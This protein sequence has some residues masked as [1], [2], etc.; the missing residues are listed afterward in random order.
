MAPARPKRTKKKLR[1]EAFS[2]FLAAA[3]ISIEIAERSIL[4]FPAMVSMMTVVSESSETRPWSP[5]LVMILSPTLRAASNSFS[6]L[7]F[8]RCGM[9]MKNHMTMKI[10]TKGNNC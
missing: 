10:R 8:R 7:A 1:Y 2:F 6:C 9:I 5:L 4:S 3:V